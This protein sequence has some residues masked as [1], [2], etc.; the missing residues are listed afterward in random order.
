MIFLNPF[1]K[2]ISKHP[3]FI[4]GELAFSNGSEL[5]ANPYQYNTEDFREWKCGWKAAFQSRKRLEEQINS[6]KSKSDSEST[7]SDT[8]Y[9]FSYIKDSYSEPTAYY[10]KST[11][12]YSNIYKIGFFITAVIAF[13]ACWIYAIVSWGFLI[14]VGMGWIPSVFIALIAG[15]IWPLI[16]LV[17]V[18]G[19]C[20]IGFII[21]KSN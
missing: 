1:K 21:Y 11:D 5:S 6:K 10:S 16:A 3:K 17:L 19:L 14:G 4:Q 7:D 20:I 2:K 12:T 18:V 15:F 9:A 13:I 8:E